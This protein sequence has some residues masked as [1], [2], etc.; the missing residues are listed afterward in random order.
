MLA[1]A[2]AMN[3][4]FAFRAATYGGLAR[5]SAAHLGARST[6][7][8]VDSPHNSIYEEDVDGASA[9]VHRHNA[10]RAYPARLMPAGTPFGSVGQA[11]LVPGMHYTSSYLCVA[12]DGARESL[13]SACHG[14]GTVIEQYARAGLSRRLRSGRVTRRYRYGQDEPELV[15][16]LDDHGVDAALSVL[17]RHDLVRPVARMRPLAVLN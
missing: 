11:V 2:A 10:C 14:A 6:H 3:Y 5:L 1:N 13:Y 9:I 15:P 4:G 17:V 12:S 16:H 8:V 7:L